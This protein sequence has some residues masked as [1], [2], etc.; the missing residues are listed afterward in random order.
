M[1]LNADNSGEPGD[2]LCT[3]TDPGAFSASG[4]HTFDAPSLGTTCPTLAAITTYFVAIA[5]GGTATDALELKVTSTSDEDS[6]GAVG[7]LI[8]NERHWI[9]ATS[10]G[11][12]NTSG[13]SH[14][15]VIK[16]TAVVQTATPGVTVSESTVSVT[17]GGTTDTYTV[18]LDTAPTG[19]VTI[20]VTETSD[21]ISLSATTLTFG[22]AT[23][24]TAQIVTV[25]AVDDTIDE[26]EETA[27]I[28]HSV[29]ASADTTDYP[30]TMTVDS[31]SVT[32]TDNDAATPGVTVSKTSVTVSEAAGTETYTIELDSQPT[33]TV[34][35][36]IASDATSNATVSPSSLSFS[37]SDWNSAKT[38]TVTGVNDDTLNA[39][40]R[41]ATISHTVSGADYGS[42]TADSVDV[43]VTDDEIAD[44][45][46][47]KNTGQIA[48]G[49][50][51]ALD[52]STTGVAQSFLTGSNAAGYAVNSI[53]ISFNTVSDTST[54]G[55]ELTASLY[56]AVSHVDGL[57]PNSALC[58]LN[59]PPTF[60]SSGVQTFSAPTTGTDLCPTLA[61]STRYFVV[62]TRAN[63]NAG[64]IYVD[65]TPNTSWDNGA[66][67]GWS[68]PGDAWFLSSSTW[69]V[70]SGIVG[71]IDV[72]GRGGSRHPRRDCFRVHPYPSPREEPPTPTPWSWIPPRPVT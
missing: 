20:A 43:S 68:L 29:S 39:S 21:D 13:E 4:V 19:D 40:N 61:A 62:V 72:E 16:G 6:G 63:T 28:T 31:V 51:Y 5:R 53:G 57:A 66:A 41:T 50:G 7:W 59:D 71:M 22:T 25:T 9:T 64:T 47:I 34:S 24:S 33:G 14:L 12:R 48:N 2:A 46:L 23:W 36:A 44:A 60:S 67:A 45:T 11:W 55:S 8:G 42:V 15:V 30:T 35:I 54:A 18:V 52:A 70:E 56:D 65:Y 26:A 37:T 32:V 58:T 17:E 69:A 1:T 49:T 10:N 38:V 3:L 27:T